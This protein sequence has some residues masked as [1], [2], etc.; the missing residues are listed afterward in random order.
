[1][2]YILLMHIILSSWCPSSPDASG[3][4]DK[5]WNLY[6]LHRSFGLF[7]VLPFSLF[8]WQLCENRLV[9]WR[10][11][12]VS[13]Q[14]ARWMQDQSCFVFFFLNLS[15]CKTDATCSVPFQIKCIRWNVSSNHDIVQV[16]SFVFCLKKGMCTMCLCKEQIYAFFSQLK[17]INIKP[18]MQSKNN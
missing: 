9:K 15:N 1:M 11:T 4:L 12:L 18:L 6:Q 2:A 10:V 13:C 14:N 5:N 8:Q 7:W 3:M 17:F 16:A